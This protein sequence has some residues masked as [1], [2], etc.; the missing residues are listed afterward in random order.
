MIPRSNLLGFASRS[1]KDTR[2]VP[3]LLICFFGVLAT[4]LFLAAPGMVWPRYLDSPIGIVVVSPYFVPYILHALG[5]PGLLENNGACG[6]GWCPLTPAGWC[7]AIGV[8]ILGAWFLGLIVKLVLF[9]R[10]K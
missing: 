1:P 10:S 9:G 8:W 5:V 6:W 2:L 7:A 4:H 3:K